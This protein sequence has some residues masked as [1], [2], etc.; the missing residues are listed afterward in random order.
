M[1][2]AHAK[3]SFNRTPSRTTKYSPFE[4]V[5]GVNPYM[6]IDFITLSMDKFVHGNV[7]NMLNLFSIIIR[8]Y[9]SGFER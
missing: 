3:F 1:K 4:A 2:V 6:P 9:E 7:K 5:Y 8:K